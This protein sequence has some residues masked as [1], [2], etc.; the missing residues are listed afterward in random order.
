MI[1]QAIKGITTENQTGMKVWEYMRKPALHY[2]YVC[3]SFI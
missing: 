2:E 1:I 3:V